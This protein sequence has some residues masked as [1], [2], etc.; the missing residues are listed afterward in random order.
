MAQF[1][2]MAVKNVQFGLKFII[3]LPA[4]LEAFEHAQFRCPLRVWMFV[5]W[6]LLSLQC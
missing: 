2:L 6:L 3:G 1:M 4:R 5:R